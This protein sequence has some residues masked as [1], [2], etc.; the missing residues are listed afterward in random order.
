MW[1]TERMTKA[2]AESTPNPTDPNNPQPRP[3]DPNN[4]NDPNRPQP[5]PQT[6][7]MNDAAREVLRERGES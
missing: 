4:P 7:D 5:R 2:S 6:E 3:V 1:H